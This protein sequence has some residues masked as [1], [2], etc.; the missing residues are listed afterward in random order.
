MS[1]YAMD[2]VPGRGETK[3]KSLLASPRYPSSLHRST[4]CDTSHMIV[5][6]GSKTFCHPSF[7]LPYCSIK[8]FSSSSKASA[9]S[10]SRSFSVINPRWLGSISLQTA[11][12]LRT[13][14]NWQAFVKSSWLTTPLWSTSRSLFQAE[15]RL[16]YFTTSIFLK[17]LSDLMTLSWTWCAST[18]LSERARLLSSKATGEPC[19]P[20]PPPPPSQ[21]AA[22]SVA[23]TPM[24]N[25]RKS[26]SLSDRCPMRAM[27]ILKSPFGGPGQVSQLA[28]HP[29]TKSA[30]SKLPKPPLSSCS[31]QALTRLLLLRRKHWRQS[32]KDCCAT[33]SMSRKVIT[34]LS[35]GAGPTSSCHKR[36]TFPLSA[37]RCSK[38]QKWPKVTG[39][40]LPPGPTNSNRH[41]ATVEP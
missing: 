19:P 2:F 7:V 21:M 17:A 38:G 3:L 34:F 24:S 33:G 41:P 5:F 37:R 30:S 8:S 10:R 36:L 13:P 25:G 14:R 1:L 29:A 31:S 40:L 32:S 27:S 20:P 23:A 22:A 35:C 6:C 4:K 39:R 15:K 9:V 28:S 11:L 26:S 18:N 16:P 12:I